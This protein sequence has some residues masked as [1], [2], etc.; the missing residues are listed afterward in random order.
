[1][2][3][4]TRATERWATIKVATVPVTFCASSAAIVLAALLA[5][6]SSADGTVE[7]QSADEFRIFLPFAEPRLGARR[8]EGSGLNL[9]E[10]IEGFRLGG[11]GLG[12]NI[13]DTPNRIG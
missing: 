8:L 4:R 3:A 12:N 9:V 2:R 13:V 10:R 7:A 5:T 6:G 1:M 11:T